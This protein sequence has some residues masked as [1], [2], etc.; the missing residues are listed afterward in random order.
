MSS[1]FSTVFALRCVAGIPFGFGVL[2]ARHR[3]RRGR[4]PVSAARREW[5]AVR[6]RLLGRLRRDARLN[7]GEQPAARHSSSARL[8]CLCILHRRRSGARRRPPLSLRARLLF[9]VHSA[10]QGQA[11][12]RTPQ[13]TAHLEHILIGSDRICLCLCIRFAR[14]LDSIFSHS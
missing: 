1:I 8:F 3:R 11:D 9:A 6:L 4:A 14:A 12:R 5:R 2:C 10:R 13:H 7:D